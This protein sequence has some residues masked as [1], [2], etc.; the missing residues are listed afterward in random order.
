[1]KHRRRYIYL[2]LLAWPALLFFRSLG[3]GDILALQYANKLHVTDLERHV[4]ALAADSTEGRLTGTEGCNKAA[5]Y[6]AT[7]FEHFMVAPVYESGYF[8]S[9]DIVTANMPHVYIA[10]DNKRYTVGVDFLS[11]FPHDSARIAEKDF[12][13]VGYGIED[14]TWND[15]AYRDVKGKIVLVKAGEPLDPFGASLITATHRP[16]KWSADPVHAY[17]L[18]RK[19]AM[20]NGAKAML[21]YDPEHFEAFKEAFER[22]YRVSRKT[23]EIQ[24]DSLYDFI[25][26]TEMMQDITGYDSIDSLYYTGKR[27]RKWNVPIRI[28]FHTQDEILSSQNVM[29][30]IEGDELPEEYI[31]VTANYDHLGKIRES[32]YPGA[33]NNATGT[34]AVIEMA[35]LFKIAEQDEYFPKR[36]IVFILFSGREQEHL[37]AKYFINHPPFS[38]KKI[39]AVVDVDMIGYVDTIST[40]PNNIFFSEELHRRHFL[41]YL[42]TANKAGPGLTLRQIPPE[43]RM[44]NIE[45]APDA[46]V[47]YEKKIP[48]ISFVNGK[49]PFNKTPDDTPDKITWDIYNERTKFIFMAVWQLANE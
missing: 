20:E 6:I 47:F 35:R 25:I 46:V 1:M 12:I 36:S 16:S 7:R 3:D 43:K 11:F 39:K 40:D 31:L 17:M 15:Y 14:P 8:Q 38:L 26:S 2:F 27:D 29:A 18:K 24:V 30:M 44:N 45:Y 42:K 41:S 13:Y 9:F 34:G 23:S 5:R 49:Y 19:A 28:G 48:W 32:I 33:N 37:G 10:T 4:L 22:M 21:Y